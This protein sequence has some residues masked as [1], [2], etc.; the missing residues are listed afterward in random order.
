M[1]TTHDQTTAI[2]ES[3]AEL[4]L[5]LT[6]EISDWAEVWICLVSLKQQKHEGN[7]TQ[8]NQSPI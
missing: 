4:L 1:A 6:D 8:G 5:Q 3:T 7:F 2:K